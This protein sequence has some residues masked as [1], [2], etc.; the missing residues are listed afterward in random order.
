MPPLGNFFSSQ[1]LALRA[2]IV[3]RA[4][5]T[6]QAGRSKL[7]SQLG[8]IVQVEVC[9]R[10][11]RGEY[12]PAVI[13]PRPQTTIACMY[14]HTSWLQQVGQQFLVCFF[15][16]K[17]NLIKINLDYSQ[18]NHFLLD[19]W[20]TRKKRFYISFLGKQN[21]LNTTEKNN[22]KRAINEL[23]CLWTVYRRPC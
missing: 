20:E 15:L 10:V 23:S 22:R 8:D 21:K 12:Q 5:L 9:Q 11:Y 7:V 13:L 2:C 17:N 3:E 14:V 18:T 19:A 4:V 6:C 16:T 1:A